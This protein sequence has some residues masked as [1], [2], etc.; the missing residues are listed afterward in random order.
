M[1]ILVVCQY[2][3]P[4]PVRI[5]DICETLVE[6]GHEVDVV[7]DVPNYPMGLIY[8]GYQH[9]EK[10]YEEIN[11]V[12]V[13]RCFTI[14]RRTGTIFRLLNYLSYAVSSSL[15]VSQLK[16]NYDVVFVNQLSPVT[17][18][19]AGVVY[20]KKYHKKLVY[21]CL[22]LWP[23][24]L[25]AGGIKRGGIVYRVFDW[26]SEKLYAQADM[27]LVTSKNF[28][29]YFKNQF[30]TDETKMRYLPQYAEDMFSPQKADDKEFVDL[31]FAGNIGAAQS[32][33]TIIEA[34]AQLKDIRN[35]RINI[36]GDGSALESCKTL[37]QKLGADN[38]IFH[39]RKKLEEMPEIYRNADAML[40]TLSDD[41]LISMTLPG[42]VQTYM[43]AGK[44]II[45]AINGETAEIIAQAECGL[46]APAEDAEILA[47]HIRTFLAGNKSVLGQNARKFYENYF[48][49]DIFIEQLIAEFSET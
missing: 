8:E 34:A 31:T 45:G 23:E 3:D 14:G 7:T 46:C 15:F 16:D 2:Y 37:A 6:M 5:T 4:E 41:P 26:I 36:V 43:A 10:R 49:K 11:G 28:I 40:V 39:G 32:I 21:Y 25:I 30:G 29:T 20:K 33:E 17:M 35:L 38:V 48:R 44:P 47:N 12:S 22:D 9:G 42:K 19:C 24:S 1:K 27:I 18:A 13:H